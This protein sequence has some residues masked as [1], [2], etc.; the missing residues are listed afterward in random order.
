MVS[1]YDSRFP[2]PKQLWT[3]H[4][5]NPPAIATARMSGG[6]HNRASARFAQLPVGEIDGPA[7][8]WGRALV[9]TCTVAVQHLRVSHDVNHGVAVVVGVHRVED[10]APFRRPAFEQLSVRVR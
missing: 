3:R 4:T 8:K 9:R 1:A 5:M 2:E 6:I 7:V 10:I